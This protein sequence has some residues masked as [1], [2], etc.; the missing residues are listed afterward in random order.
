MAVSM[1]LMLLFVQRPEEQMDPQVQVFGMEA[2]RN[3]LKKI[4]VTKQQVIVGAITFT[5]ADEVRSY[6]GDRRYMEYIESVLKKMASQSGVV[7]ADSGVF[8]DYPGRVY[9]IVDTQEGYSEELLK[10]AYEKLEDFINRGGDRGTLLNPVYSIFKFPDRLVTI[11]EALNY[12]R[13]QEYFFGPNEHYALAEKFFGRKDFQIFN[14]IDAVLNR[15]ID[16]RLFEMYYQPIYC[17]AE[18]RFVS[19]E[20]LIR[21]NDPEFG[22]ISPGML[23]GVA[24]QRGLMNVIGNFVLD[25]VFSFVGSEEF[26]KLGLDY[27]EVNLS[28]H[29]CVNPEL[30]EL[31]ELMA[32]RYHVLPSQI[33][34]E[35]TET[36]NADFEIAMDRNMEILRDMGYTFSLDDY[37]TG[38]SNI[39]RVSRLPLSIIKIDKEMVDAMGEEK[40][41]LILKNSVR[42]MKDIHMKIVAEG[43]EDKEYA[44]AIIDLGCDY[45][46]GY[47]YSKP[48]PKDVLI[49]F[50]Q[51]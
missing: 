46:Q 4:I 7:G 3:E 18:D 1:L 27:V 8:F 19:A 22:F 40:G 20:A 10:Y 12:G 15:A 26:K 31:V 30:P 25:M 29:Q 39:H 44:D 47:Y 9:T 36:A 45:I 11:D 50:L 32:R 5:N 38:Y 35:V 17:P 49:Q 51:K 33:N 48:L 21:L 28:I 42:M 14:N 13:N 2:Y 43:V 34:F 24:E 41:F 37:G 6:M 16:N 23:I